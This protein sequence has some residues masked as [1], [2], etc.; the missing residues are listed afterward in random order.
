MAQPQSP[1]LGR[2]AP[3]AVNSFD[4]VNQFFGRYCAGILPAVISS[5]Q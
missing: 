3:F 1:S 5:F 2:F 4:A